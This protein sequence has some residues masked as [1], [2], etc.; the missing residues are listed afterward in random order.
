MI[1][2]KK[3]QHSEQCNQLL[4]MQ[5]WILPAVAVQRREF[6]PLQEPIRY[7]DLLNS[8]CSQAEKKIKLISY[9]HIFIT[10][11]SLVGSVD[12]NMNCRSTQIE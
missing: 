12:G 3:L 4:M 9:I 10:G 5:Q 7:Q 6:H 2:K 8:A 1:I 11:S